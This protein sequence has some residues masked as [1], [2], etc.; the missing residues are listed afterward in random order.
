MSDA[1][2]KYAAASVERRRRISGGWIRRR[3]D[4]HI[5]VGVEIEISY[6][7]SQANNR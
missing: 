5:G 6:D 2:V 7:I 3:T 4:H 1:E